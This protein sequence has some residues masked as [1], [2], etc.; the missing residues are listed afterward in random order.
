MADTELSIYCSKCAAEAI[1][2]NEVT[3]GGGTKRDVEFSP[4]SSRATSAEPLIGTPWKWKVPR[5][6]VVSGGESL[7]FRHMLAAE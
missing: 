1:G 6:C 2:H 4:I 5:A 7:C 3:D